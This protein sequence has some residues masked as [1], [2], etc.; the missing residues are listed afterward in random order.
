M[1]L[2]T[3]V[4]KTFFA[5]LRLRPISLPCEVIADCNYRCQRQPDQASSTSWRRHFGKMP[6]YIEHTRARWRR[7]ALRRRGG[8]EGGEACGG[9][10]T[11]ATQSVGSERRNAGKRKT[12]FIDFV[13][14]AMFASA[15]TGQAHSTRPTVVVVVVVDAAERLERTG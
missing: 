3:I 9:D 14:S 7:S 13:T 4:L 10:G 11:K 6:F 5:L 2:I 12:C 15:T 1:T 8:S